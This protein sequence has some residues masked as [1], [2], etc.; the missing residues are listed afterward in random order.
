MLRQF[1]HPHDVLLDHFRG[2]GACVSRN[3]IYAR[4]D[5]QRCRFEVND[6]R[7]KAD[8]HLGRGLPANAAVDVG[9][10]REGFVQPPK[11]RD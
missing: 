2:R 5:N 1:C 6:V 9:L 11:V 8:E 3:V 10:P 7:I 4:Q